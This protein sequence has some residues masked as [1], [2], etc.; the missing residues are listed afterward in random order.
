MLKCIIFDMDG[1]LIDSEKVYIQG[2]YHAFLRHNFNLTLEDV[3]VFIGMSGEAELLELDKITNDRAV[4]LQIM[5]DMLNFAKKE[6]TDNTVS[7]KKGAKELLAY[8]RD[9]GF[10]IGLATSTFKNSALVTLDTTLMLPFFDFLVFGDD[11]S[12]PKPDKMIYEL[13]IKKSG[14]KASECIVIEDSHSGVTSAIAANLPVIQL[15]DDVTPLEIATYTVRSLS[16]IK[17]I[18]ESSRS[19]KR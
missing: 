16:E 4:T 18:I 19:E 17:L 3:K 1:T 13:A 10:N 6:M 9:G 11:V 15:I 8:F 12:R 14:F 5:N 2:F 7:L